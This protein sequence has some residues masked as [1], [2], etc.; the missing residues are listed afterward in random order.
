MP[1]PTQREIEIPLLQ[2]LQ[3]A[4]G[5]LPA[6]EAYARVTARFPGL[7]VDDVR[8]ETREG[9]SAWTNRI[10]WVRQHLKVKGQVASPA[11]G[12]WSITEL[13][14]R[15]LQDGRQDASA[16]S[17]VPRRNTTRVRANG[18]EVHFDHDDLA[19]AL[20]KVGQA[21]GFEAKWKP[22]ANHIRPDN[23]AIASK[24]KSLDVGWKIGNLA[25]VAI[26]VQVG[27]S[28]PDLIYRFQQVH[29]WSLR[30]IVVTVDAFRAEIDE[31]LRIGRY[32]FSDK[33]VV[34]SPNEVM[35]A[36]R[37]L[38]VLLKLKAKIFES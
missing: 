13:G 26:E 27:G 38:E 15:R 8:T 31:T 29:Q 20:M 33:V 32:P 36:T 17:T 19:K 34:L 3:R 21:F 9:R 16:L 30:L 28:V 11:R 18:R 6:N 25:W 7:S 22:Q 4:G 37:S 14:R 35:A 1:L 5:S 2:E 23:N 24:K 10:Q 12:V